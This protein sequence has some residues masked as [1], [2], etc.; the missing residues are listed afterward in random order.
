MSLESL[1]FIRLSELCIFGL[2]R[3]R[4]RAATQDAFS[5]YEPWENPNYYCGEMKI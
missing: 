2:E 5:R 3:G 4:G 1:P